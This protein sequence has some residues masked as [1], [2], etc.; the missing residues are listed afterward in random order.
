MPLNYKIACRDI[1]KA[2]IAVKS[3]EISTPLTSKVSTLQTPLN[4]LSLASIRA[5]ASALITVHPSIDLLL[6]NAGAAVGSFRRSEDGFEATLAG[7]HLG[8]MALALQVIEAGA[9]VNAR[10]VVVSSSLHDQKTRMG[11][12]DTG[13]TF[14]FDELKGIVKEDQFESMVMYRKSKLANV[15]FAYELARY[16]EKNQL[17]I[18]VNALCPGFVPNTGLSRE[19]S[20]FTNLIMHYVLPLFPFTSTADKSSDHILW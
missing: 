20:F 12:S 2:T 13:F 19:S 18:T 17:K 14:D 9:L 11:K 8:H 5:Y 15:W 10:V 1:S 4:L 6:L 7:N 3:L 16:V